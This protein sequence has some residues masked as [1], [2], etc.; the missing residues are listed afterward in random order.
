MRGSCQVRDG[1]L[2]D[3]DGTSIR[4]G[5][6]YDDRGFRLDV[7]LLPG[8]LKINYKIENYLFIHYL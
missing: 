6:S 3:D 2:P 7:V 5:N 1:L 8:H 4:L